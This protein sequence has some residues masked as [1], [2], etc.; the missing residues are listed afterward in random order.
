MTDSS[1]VRAQRSRLHKRHDHSLC[2]PDR[3]P[4]AK[5][6]VD[7]ELTQP[8]AVERPRF[9]EAG[10]QLWRDMTAEGDLA[11]MAMVLLVEACRIVDRLETL[12]ATL[13]GGQAQWLDLD[14]DE[15]GNTATVIV[16]KA[17]AESRQQATAL[18]QLVGEIRQFTGKGKVSNSG[19]VTKGGGSIADLN[20]RIAARRGQSAG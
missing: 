6:A 11:P 19:S 9:D 10:S 5:K 18:K 4:E 20:S 12:D 16:D 15:E 14:V 17:L 7:P 8:K 2:H 13:Q 3:C 1:A